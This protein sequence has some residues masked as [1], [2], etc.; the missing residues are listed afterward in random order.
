MITKMRKLSLA[1]LL[2]CAGALGGCASTGGADPADLEATWTLESFG[3]VTD[4]EPADPT[5]TTT[6]TFVAGGE[7]N[8]NGG[9]NNFGTTYEAS[10]DGD[11]EF[12][13][14]ASTLMAGPDNAMEQESR[15]FEAMGKTARFEFNEGK[16]ILNDMGNNVLAVMVQE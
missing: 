6:L 8:G 4:L 9:V 14:I 11:L 15:F 10:D 16:V 1:M 13:E 7:A 5:V 12:G 2:V 3:G